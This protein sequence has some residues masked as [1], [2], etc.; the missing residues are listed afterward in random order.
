MPKFHSGRRMHRSIAF[1][2]AI[3]LLVAGSSD[4]LA[5]AVVNAT[6][7]ANP[8][9]TYSAIGIE[10]NPVGDGTWTTSVVGKVATAGAAQHFGNATAIRDGRIITGLAATPTGDGYWIVAHDG[11]VFAHGDAVSQGSPSTDLVLGVV[12]DIEATPT[13]DGY[14]LFTDRG[15]VLRFGDAVGFGSPASLPSGTIVDAAATPSGAG[16]WLVSRG[17]RVYNF[18]DADFFGD[19]RSSAKSAV[20]GIAST[21][22]GEGYLLATA[23]GG[24]RDFGDARWYGGLRYTCPGETVVGIA[25]TPAARGYYLILATGRSFAFSPIS[26]TAACGPTSTSAAGEAARELFLRV[27]AERAAR[28]IAPLRWDISL[29][30]AAT[31]WSAEMSTT[32]FRHSNI[33]RLLV[34]GRFNLVGENIAWASGN[35]AMAGVIHVNWMESTGHRQNMLSPSFEVI[36]IGVFCSPDGKMWATQNFGRFASSG[37]VAAPPAPPL[38]PITQKSVGTAGC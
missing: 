19:I 24:V 6:A 32:G 10:A 11:T 2:T 34:D 5:G 20:A 35:N 29:G 17:G 22:S 18:G 27:N 37:T 33:T 21:S 14:W 8:A 15:Q 31:A 26:G 30:T 25:T 4:R 28:G 38:N 3:T 9:F 1:A 23:T 16:Y 12:I 7:T 36:G 13:G